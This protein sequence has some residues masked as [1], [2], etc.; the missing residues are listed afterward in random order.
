M[1]NHSG[2]FMDQKKKCYDKVGPIP[3]QIM[4]TQL[5]INAFSMGKSLFSGHIKRILPPLVI[6]LLWF[7]PKCHRME[8][9]CVPYGS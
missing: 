1:V 5:K 2:V 8:N 4:V 7:G 9:Q 3:D 6:T